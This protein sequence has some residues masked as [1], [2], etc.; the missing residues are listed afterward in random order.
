MQYEQVVTYVENLLHDRDTALSQAYRKSIELRAYG[1][2]PIDPSRGRFLELLAKMTKPNRVLEIGPGGGYSSLWFL[3]G[4]G[5]TS[6]L[7]VVEHNPH[8]AVEFR[9]TMRRAGFARRVTIHLGPAL[10][11][12]PRLK[13]HFDIVFIDAD[14]DEYPWYLKQAMRLTRVGSIILADNLLWHGSV[15]GKKPRK[16]ADGIRE[17]TRMIFNDRRLRSL[18]IPLGDGISLSY[19]VHNQFRK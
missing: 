16:G 7:E 15:I 4:M 3:K 10:H 8:V 12:L 2:V 14:K 11:I 19:R 13:G 17:Y 5:R 9:K 6:R 18:V 1:V